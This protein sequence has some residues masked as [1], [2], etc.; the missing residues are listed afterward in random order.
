MTVTEFGMVL[1]AMG[2]NLKDRAHKRM[3]YPGHPDTVTAVWSGIA[4]AFVAG[5]E[6]CVEIG[7][8]NNRG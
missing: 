2:T 8:E 4:D 7:E 5:A 1:L 6:K 3:R